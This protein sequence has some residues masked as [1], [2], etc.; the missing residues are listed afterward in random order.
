MNV[1][2]SLFVL[3][4]AARCSGCRACELACFAAHRA[5]RPWTVGSVSSPVTPRLYLTRGAAACMPVQCHHCED[6]PCMK[7]CLTGALQ[8]VDGAVI[9][10]QRKCIGCR[11]CALACPFGAIEVFSESELP[12]EQGSALKLV[13]KCDLCAEKPEPA[14]V[15]A[16]PNTA[17]RLVNAEMELAEKRIASLNASEAFGSV[18]AACAAC[19]EDEGGRV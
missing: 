14:C 9:L 18:G 12:A 1:E 4:D 11:A 7:S 8:R 3:A 2:Q 15:A 6:A 19:G 16:C 10:D 5:Q 13:Y 17:L